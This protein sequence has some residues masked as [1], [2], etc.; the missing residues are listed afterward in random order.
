[1][2][3][4]L[5]DRLAGW[6]GWGSPTDNRTEYRIPGRPEAGSLGSTGTVRGKP[7]TNLLADDVDTSFYNDA[8][9]YGGRSAYA[10]GPQDLLSPTSSMRMLE[11][12]E[13]QFGGEEQQRRAASFALR[14]HG[15][16]TIEGQPAAMPPMNG[17][18]QRV[19]PLGLPP[20]VPM[21]AT[22]QPAPPGNRPVAPQTM[23]QMGGGGQPQPGALTPRGADPV[24]RP[25]FLGRARDW[26]GGEAF[27]AGQS[28]SRGMVLAQA[29]GN[30]GA[31][32]SATGRVGTGLRMANKGM[33]DAREGERKR[34]DSEEERQ[35]HRLQMAV[36]LRELEQGPERKPFGSKEQG[37]WVQGADGKP[38]QLVPPGGDMPKAPGSIESALFDPRP[39]IRARA[40][41]LRDEAAA[42]RGTMTPAQQE[43]HALKLAKL[44]AD[45]ARAGRPPGAGTPPAPSALAK[46]QQELAAMAP[47][48][49]RRAQH[50]QMI[51]RTIRGGSGGDTGPPT[52]ATLRE[53]DRALVN[54]VDEIV[55]SQGW[56]AVPANDRRAYER[57]YREQAAPRRTI[58]PLT[59]NVTVTQPDVTDLPVPPGY[60][61]AAAGA[62]PPT[63]GVSTGAPV[64]GRERVS[65]ATD[66]QSMYKRGLPVIQR[67]EE[68][69]NSAGLTGR[70]GGETR[71]RLEQEI[72]DLISLLGSPA[73]GNAGVLQPSDLERYRNELGGVTGLA[74]AGA[75]AVGYDPA[76]AALDELKQRLARALQRNLPSK[77]EAQTM[78][79]E[80]QAVLLPKVNN[81]E[82]AEQMPPG[83]PFLMPN[84]KIGMR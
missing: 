80:E 33:W 74:A 18:T 66:A 61:G 60:G 1:M 54:R 69:I 28:M 2:P 7:K 8:G 9:A 40:E 41:A 3:D 75:A 12:E 14:R 27:P 53:R 44:K 56:D 4:F 78:T 39:E 49:P 76:K 36:K 20:D 68:L 15:L 50:E 11:A 6:F 13:P 24:P 42:R 21:A 79:P 63:P 37:W 71:A 30:F 29:L 5:A 19:A 83:V 59:G 62:P 25:N 55:E 43:E 10:P 73:M 48:D 65:K 26:L 45:I 16:P 64:L 52:E 35:Y 31:G 47:D 81:A 72:S 23:P 84:G 32:L 58:D 51:E 77:E 46:L 34:Q 70:A 22:G 57:I 82:E 67:I 38:E 17:P